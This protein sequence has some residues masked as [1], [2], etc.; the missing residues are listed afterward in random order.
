M[1]C[2]TILQHTITC[3]IEKHFIYPVISNFQTAHK[4]EFSKV[5]NIPFIIY[6]ASRSAYNPAIF[7]FLLCM[8]KLVL[9][10]RHIQTD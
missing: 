4:T 10:L 3:N 2:F 8:K 7:D 1:K 9:T 6:T 5:E